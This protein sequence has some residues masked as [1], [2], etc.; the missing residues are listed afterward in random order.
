MAV[1][2]FDAELDDIKPTKTHA[3]PVVAAAPVTATAAAPAP[4]PA[5]VT[6]PTPAPAAVVFDDEPAKPKAAV[7]SDADN[8]DTD[9]DD[10]DVYK[11]PGQ[12]DQCRP[13]KKGSGADAARFSLIPKEW[14]KL[15]S[16][17]THFLE[18]PGKDQKRGRYRCLSPMGSEEPGYCCL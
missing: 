10:E 13:G 11:R 9:F 6:V 1:P 15:Q 5:A 14:V 2:T 8:C 7:K 17:K 4:A 16:S 18:T 3:Q 12:L